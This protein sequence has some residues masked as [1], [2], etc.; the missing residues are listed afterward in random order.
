MNPTMKVQWMLNLLVKI[1][2]MKKTYE[3]PNMKVVSLMRRA[4][5]LQSS[6]PNDE[7]PG[8]TGK[9]AMDPMDGP[10]NG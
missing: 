10:Y 1:S 4:D 7:T 3:T 5:L 2:D 9:I 8:I 6:A